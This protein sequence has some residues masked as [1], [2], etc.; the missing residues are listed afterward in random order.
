MK[1]NTICI[2]DDDPIFVFATKVLLNHNKDFA[3]DFMV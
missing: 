1:I 3:T 2:I